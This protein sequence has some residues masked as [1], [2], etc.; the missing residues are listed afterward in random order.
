MKQ[1]YQ[2]IAATIQNYS[3]EKQ[4]E[5]VKLYPGISITFLSLTGGKPLAFSH[6]PLAHVL[7]INY[8]LSGRIGWHM[9]SGNQIYLGPGDFS[10]HTMDVCAQ[11]SIAMPGGAYQGILICVDL[12]VL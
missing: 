9:D 3:G 4:L 10:L 6:E 8:C 12:G 2:K 11:S 7:E 1:E 5:L